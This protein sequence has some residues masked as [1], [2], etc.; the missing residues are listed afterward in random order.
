MNTR[1]QTTFFFFHPACLGSTRN[2]YSID[3]FPI[4]PP[5]LPDWLGWVVCG[6]GGVQPRL[7]LASH[8]IARFA[9]STRRR[10][11][12]R[13]PFLPRLPTPTPGLAVHPPQSP[14]ADPALDSGGHSLIGLIEFS[15]VAALGFD[16]MLT[17][18]S[19]SYPTPRTHTHPQGHFDTTPPPHPVC[20]R[21]TCTI[22]P[23][24]RERRSNPRETQRCAFVVAVCVAGLGCACV[25]WTVV[26]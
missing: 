12:M 26:K 10:R 24:I 6:G 13:C 17:D 9:A 23:G 15:P 22:R 5:P 3:R 2:S 14:S 1:E 19:P 18:C 20:A 25:G 16:E 8:H 21:L 4:R 7:L 11:P